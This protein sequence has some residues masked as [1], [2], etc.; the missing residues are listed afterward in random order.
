VAAGGNGSLLLAEDGSVFS[1][2][3]NSVGQAGLGVGSPMFVSVATP[4]D[5]TNLGG[6]KITQ[7]AA[8][9]DH[10]L[11]LADDG[12]VFSFG[13]NEYGGLGTFGGAAWIATPIVTTN[14]GARKISEVAAGHNH[15]LLLADDGSMFSFGENVVGKTGLGTS[16]G[17]TLVATAIVTTNLSN[18]T[19]TH[20]DGGQSHSLLIT[21]PRLPG[22]YNK[23]GTVDA[24]DYVV[25][26]RSVGQTGAVLAADGDQDHQIEADDYNVWRANFGASLGPGSGSASPPSPS[27]PEPSSV[28][29]ALSLLSLTPFR[30]QNLK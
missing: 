13:R 12:S 2:G 4:I 15:S 16:S 10:K 21:V 25:W 26:R 14:L 8:G 19:V 30:R 23:D 5:N 3:L 28:V 18:L 24:A 6:R 11:L 1:F 17:N 9:L 7:V 27:V 22:D 29:L 20:V